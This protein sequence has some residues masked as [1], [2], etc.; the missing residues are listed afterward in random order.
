M[1]RTWTGARQR[2]PAVCQIRLLHNSQPVSSPATEASTSKA[3][4]D[5][6]VEAPKKWTPQSKRTGLIALKRGM[7]SMWNDQGVKFPVTILQVEDCQVTAN[8]KTPKPDHTVY[9]AV[10]V[11]AVNRSPKSVTNQMQGHFRKA[12]V[13]PKRYVKEFPVTSDAH[14]PV[15]TTL[16]A[17]H[18]V[19]GQYV[20][21][22]AKSIGKGFQGVMKKW[23][24]H[25]LAASHG[26][27]F[28]DPGRIFPGKKMAGRMGGKQVTVQNLA[29]VRVDTALNLVYVR[30]QVPGVDDAPIYIRDAK[31]VMDIGRHNAAKGK[32]E[33]ILP[34]GVDDLPFPAGTDSL[35][36]TL[37]PIIEAPAY[38]RSPFTPPE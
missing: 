10:Q 18:F 31:K 26:K 34:K 2:I 38:R 23:G 28:D 7:T 22:V 19:P 13:P 16:S 6:V 8:I 21:C 17:I 32:E 29:V 36:K 1:L 5:A 9:H 15:G 30:G 25:G 4:P 12:E 20:D 27:S 33:K 11:A 24:F 3:E 14:V 35:A 37:P